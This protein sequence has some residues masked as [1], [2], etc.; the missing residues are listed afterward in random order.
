LHQFV[1]DYPESM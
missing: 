1:I